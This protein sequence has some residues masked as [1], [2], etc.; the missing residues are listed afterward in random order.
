MEAHLISHVSRRAA[1][2]GLGAFFSLSLQSCATQSA[3]PL[4]AGA[5]TRF[6]AIRIDVSPLAQNGNGPEAD[7]LSQDLPAL[8]Q[9]AFAAHMAS[10]NAAADTLLVRIDSVSLG[11][12]S[13]GGG[14]W[15]SRPIDSIQGAGIVLAPGGAV[16]ATYPLLSTGQT[17][18]FFTQLGDIRIQRIRVTQIA[19]SFAYWLP[20]QMGL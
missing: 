9:T 15:D 1:L 13:S 12:W 16:I 10:G 19:Q 4:P 3:P 7:W 6:K 11:T 20:R 2:L 18:V 8:L 14:I 5:Q 17:T